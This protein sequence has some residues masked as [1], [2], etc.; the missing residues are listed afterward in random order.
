MDDFEKIRKFIE[1]IDE[2]NVIFTRHAY[3]RFS[4]RQMREGLV[5]SFLRTPDRLFLVERQ[6]ARG[7]WEEKFRIWFK[8]SSR[9]SLVVVIVISEKDLY[10]L[11]CWPCDKKWTGM[12]IK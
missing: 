1:N 2:K 3:D 12:K 10:V 8:M 11:S 4:Q 9:Y 6:S 5:N 7:L